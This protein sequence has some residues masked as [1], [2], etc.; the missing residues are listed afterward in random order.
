MEKYLQAKNKNHYVWEKYLQNWAMDGKVYWVTPK[1][2]K[3]RFDS[4]KGMCMELGFY[5]IHQLEIKD[6]QYLKAWTSKSPKHLED[7]HNKLIGDFVRISEII[8]A[9]EMVNNNNPLLEK[10]SKALQHNSIE[11]L[12]CGVE[13]GARS[14]IENL[15]CGD[16]SVLKKESNLIGLYSY[17]GH[18]IT[19]TKAIKDRFISSAHNISNSELE[20]SMLCLAERNWW[21][22]SYILGTNIGWSLYESRNSESPRI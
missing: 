3:I 17:L 15:A 5:K 8:K 18:Q 2:K 13:N 21:L 10:A 6:V 20:K 22:L 9:Y 19:R 14:A 4:T 7:M 16:L 1:N 12:Y 11:N